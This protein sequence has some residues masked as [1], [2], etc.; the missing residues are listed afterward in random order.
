[1]SC[2]PSL[3]P[4]RKVVV[5]EDTYNATTNVI[6]LQHKFSMKY[7]IP[8]ELSVAHYT[9]SIFPIMP[10]IN[11]K[12]NEL[13]SDSWKKICSNK[14]ILESGFEVS[15][16]TLFYNDFYER[17][18]VVDESHKIEA[19][20]VA[21]S[22]GNNKIADKGA[23]IIRIINYILSLSH[24]DDQTQFRLYTLGKAHAQRAIRPYM[25]SVFVQN[26]LYTISNQLGVH[27]THEVMEAWVNMFAFVMKS[28]LPLAIKNHVLEN[29]MHIN[30]KTEFSS[31]H[32][33]VQVLEKKYDNSNKVSARSIQ[34]ARSN[35]NLTNRTN[36]NSHQG[37]PMIPRI[38]ISGKEEDDS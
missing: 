8:I 33:K 30:T 29:E 4:R 34:S 32:V 31:D 9:P 2:F 18:S 11:P 38:I 20:L 37:T 28:M 23:I 25:Y 15:G 35:H 17:L 1:M 5:T 14:E 22:S 10:I 19:V 16:I 12:I 26:M 21:H 36:T 6:D 27:A 13:C 24:N 7:A 3:F